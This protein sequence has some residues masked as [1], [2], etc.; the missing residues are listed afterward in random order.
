[1]KLVD[2]AGKAK[3]R[4]SDFPPPIFLLIFLQILCWKFST[5]NEDTTAHRV[6]LCPWCIRASN[7]VKPTG[8][9]NINIPSKCL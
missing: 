3:P 6:L 8:Q 9:T 7:V 5:P 2:P 1:M 4:I